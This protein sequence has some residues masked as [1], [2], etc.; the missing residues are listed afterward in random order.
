MLRSTAEIGFALA[1]DV[2]LHRQVTL[3]C[4]EARARDNRNLDRV[5]GWLSLFVQRLRFKPECLGTLYRW[6]DIVAYE[7]SLRRVLLLPPSGHRT[8]SCRQL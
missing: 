6:C 7:S 3:T 8:A 1:L 2:G 5:D 4:I